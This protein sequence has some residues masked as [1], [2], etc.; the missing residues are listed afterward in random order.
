MVH[1]CVPACIRLIFH[2]I[3]NRVC[4]ALWWKKKKRDDDKTEGNRERKRDG[5]CVT[6]VFFCAVIHISVLVHYVISLFSFKRTLWRSCR[7][8]NCYLNISMS[9]STRFKL[10]TFAWFISYWLQHNFSKWAIATQLPILFF[11]FFLFGEVIVLSIKHWQYHVKIYLNLGSLDRLDARQ[12]T[13]TSIHKHFL[14]HKIWQLLLC[15]TTGTQ[16]WKNQW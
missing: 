2:I 4:M 1:W 3:S 8:H 12:L 13:F 9:C 7:C 11:L 14:V 6:H 10:A 5:E 16:I 15:P